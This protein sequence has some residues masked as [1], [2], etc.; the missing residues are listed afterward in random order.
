M[1]AFEDLFP[2]K[3][4]DHAD[5]FSQLFKAAGEF[6]E[7]TGGVSYINNHDHVEKPLDDRLGNLKYVYILIR[8]LNTCF[9]LHADFLLAKHCN[10]GLHKDPSNVVFV[11]NINLKIKQYLHLSS[12]N[13]PNRNGKQF[14]SISGFVETYLG[15]F[16]LSLGMKILRYIMRI[17]LLTSLLH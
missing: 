17:V 12:G 14:Y 6:A 16:I 3:L 5:L 15:N 1:H 9:R 13:Y 7:F 4:N 10:Y 2:L 11:P 8:E